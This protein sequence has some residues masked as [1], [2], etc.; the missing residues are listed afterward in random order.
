[1]AADTLPASRTAA[2]AAR[3]L[4][5]LRGVLHDRRRGLLL[6]SIAI[7]AVSAMYTSFYP[8]MGQDA[9]AIEPFMENMPEGLISALGMDQIGTAAGYLQSTVFG[10]LGPALL[11]VFAIGSGARTLAGGEE[12][13]T[14]ELE[15][16]HPVSRTR[17]YLERLVGLWLGAGVLAGAVFVVVAALAVVLDMD[18]GADRIVAGVVS[19]LLLGLAFGTLALAVGAATGR[20][21]VAL[22]A[23]AAVAVSAFVAQAIGP[24]VDGL[25][26]LST[27]SPWNWYIG[28]DPL[29]DGFDWGGL[30][31]LAGLTLVSAAVGLWRYRDRDLG[32]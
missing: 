23:A 3:P 8:M 25:G 9:A 17:V 27:I 15:L 29:F 20:R 4:A 30:A 28:G 6:W 18:L 19:L 22:A 24:V 5:V 1:V 11:L 2:G 21:G 31:L 32:V 7:G 13:G 10:L 16:A 14:L 12:D 26:W